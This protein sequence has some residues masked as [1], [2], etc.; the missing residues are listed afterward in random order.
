MKIK[1]DFEVYDRMGGNFASVIISGIN[2]RSCL[3]QS[4]DELGLYDTPE[5]IFDYE[6]EEG[7]LTNQE[8]LDKII[9]QSG[10]GSDYIISITDL[11]N[12]NILYSD[13]GPW[14]EIEASAEVSSSY[15]NHA[16][17]SDV[18]IES[19]PKS[20]YKFIIYDMDDDLLKRF[21]DDE[22]EDV[23]EFIENNDDAGALYIR[24]YSSQ[25]T[26]FSKKP[27]YE[28]FLFWERDSD[29]ISKLYKL[30][31]LEKADKVKDD[32]LESK[33]TEEKSDDIYDFIEDLYNLRKESIASE[34][35]YGLGNLVFKEFRNLGYLDNLKQLRKK[36]KSKELSL[37]SININESISLQSVKKELLRLKD[38]D[39][40]ITDSEVDE[41]AKAIF[42]ALEKEQQELGI[43]YKNIKE[44]DIDGLIDSS[45]VN[46][47]FI[48]GNKLLCLEVS[49]DEIEW[50]RQHSDSDS[51]LEDIRKVGQGSIFDP[52]HKDD[53]K[54]WFTK[55]DEFA[56][57]YKKVFDLGGSYQPFQKYD[58]SIVQKRLPLYYSDTVKF[59]FPKIFYSEDSVK[60]IR[61]KLTRY[62]EKNKYPFI[63]TVSGNLSYR[64]GR[65]FDLRVKYQ[66]NSF[67]E[68]IE[69]GK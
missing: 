7:R 29:P 30:L 27:K 26:G 10:D 45:E 66:E 63:I 32:Y 58:G 17:E 8:L 46:T 16:D 56:D 52:A 50:F 42:D 38:P 64:D 28:S 2:L 54:K 57:L 51:F 19:L 25:A 20:Y 43:K 21:K 12:N 39:S 48:L 9:G 61:D 49:S 68:N 18:V 24:E 1:I 62:I 37:E 60:N 11:T 5:D 47:I 14:E 41:L 59:V 36:E 69:K 23:V 55:S 3:L 31:E 4:L 40:D 65:V 15:D 35:E 13:E 67:I 53:A 6:K 44:A 34:G 33:L 22:V